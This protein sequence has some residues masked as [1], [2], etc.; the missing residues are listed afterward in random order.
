MIVG[1]AYICAAILL[2]FL[3]LLARRSDEKGEIGA[4]A[5]FFCYSPVWTYAMLFCALIIVILGTF[6]CFGLRPKP[7]ELELIIVTSILTVVLCFLLYSYRY[8]KDFNIRL[9]DDGLAIRRV[10]TSKL[11]PYHLIKKIVMLQGGRGE[12]AFILFDENNKQL[13]K[14]SGSLSNLDGLCAGVR[15]R[16]IKQE[17]IFRKRDMWG[18]WS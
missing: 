3:S 1:G 13:L 6:L 14:L 7:K 2:S 16:T 10:F 11:I 5:E 4:D 17:V 9:T 12:K 8:V 18:N 15:L